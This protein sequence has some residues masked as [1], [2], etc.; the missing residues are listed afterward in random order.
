MLV[1]IRNNLV[2][3]LMV[4][5]FSQKNILPLTDHLIRIQVKIKCNDNIHSATL[6]FTFYK[7]HFLFRRKNGIS[8]GACRVYLPD[9]QALAPTINAYIFIRQIQ[10]NPLWWR[11]TMHFQVPT[12][13]GPQCRLRRFVA[14]AAYI[15]ESSV[16]IDRCKQERMTSGKITAFTSIVD[17][18][19]N[20]SSNSNILLFSIFFASFYAPNGIQYELLSRHQQRLKYQSK[21][22][23][24]VHA[25]VSIFSV[26]ARR[27]VIPPCNIE[28]GRK[29]C[30]LSR[31]LK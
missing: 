18:L 21:N 19:A 1:S 16:F 5:R 22:I 7:A 8:M 10:C 30:I 9:V 29:I 13:D 11:M 26:S 28:K 17:L 15:G 31:K 14:R 24:W 3:P 4:L 6:N 2:L 20:R 23:V 12:E 25:V 27:T